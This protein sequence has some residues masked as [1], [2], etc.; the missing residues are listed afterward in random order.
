MRKSASP[1]HNP[2]LQHHHCEWCQ[3]VVINHNDM[4]NGFYGMIFCNY[5]CIDHWIVEHTKNN[6]NCS[7][8]GHK[9]GLPQG[10]YIQLDYYERGGKAFC[11]FECMEQE[12]RQEDRREEESGPR[13]VHIKDWRQVSTCVQDSCSRCGFTSTNALEMKDHRCPNI[14]KEDLI[15]ESLMCARQTEV[16][17]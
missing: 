6:P 17:T 9:C 1:S 2:A 12:K 10:D 14:R 5:E 16:Q 4:E 15:Y 13:L 11:T 7:I 8:C 3:R